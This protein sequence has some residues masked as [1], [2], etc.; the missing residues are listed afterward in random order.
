MAGPEGMKRVIVAQGCHSL[1]V[2][3]ANAPPRA[4]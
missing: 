1:V 2:V 4:A 3:I